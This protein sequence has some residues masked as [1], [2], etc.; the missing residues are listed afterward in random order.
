MRQP[1]EKAEAIG[2]R[3][4]AGLEEE[5]LRQRASLTG[6]IE[7]LTGELRTA[8][9]CP[10]LWQDL[11]GC[12]AALG[13]HTTAIETLRAGVAKFPLDDS[14]HYA[15]IRLLQ[16]SGMDDEAFAAGERACDLLPGDFS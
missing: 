5:R 1:D 2:R 8:G 12:H 9:A 6:R 10:Q 4:Q 7:N 14:L 15:L 13:D 3:F 11:A 16:K